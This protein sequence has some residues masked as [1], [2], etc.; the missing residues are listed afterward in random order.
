MAEI[1]TAH[2]EL[3]PV[4]ND[5]A[6]DAIVERIAAAVAEG[7]ARGMKE[8]QRVE[9]RLVNSAMGSQV[10]EEL[11]AAMDRRAPKLA[12]G[13]LRDPRNTRLS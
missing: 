10:A 12:A 13:G 11:R 2:I 4:V 6:L 3:K 5:E 7:V 9:V 8:A 1:G